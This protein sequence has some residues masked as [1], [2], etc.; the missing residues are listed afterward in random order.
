MNLELSEA[1]NKR[2]S[3]RKFKSDTVPSELITEI[4]EAARLAP[5]GTNIQP[6]RFVIIKSQ[7]KREALSSATILPFV[8][9][10]PVVLACCIDKEAVT[11]AGKKVTELKEV[12]AFADTPLENLGTENYRSTQMDEAAA[13]AYLSLNLAIAIDHATLRAT[14][15]GLGTCWV[16]M[17]DK[18]KVK[19]ILNLEDRYT[20]MALIP[21]G[22]PDQD[23][24]PRP[25]MKL[26]EIIIKEV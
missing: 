1:I 4:I 19:E 2:R 23:P 3:I 17:F 5:S 18:A 16:M 6:W 13:N 8:H 9:Q 21:V 12:G 14:D 15:L 11:N 22:Y 25:R 20:V 24:A 26:E 7:A 10:A